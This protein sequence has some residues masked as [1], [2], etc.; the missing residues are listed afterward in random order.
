MIDRYSLIRFF[1]VG[2]KYLSILAVPIIFSIEDV[3]LFSLLLGAERFIS[4]ICSMEVHSYFNRR[5]IHRNHSIEY[6]N[7]QHLPIISIGVMISFIF[8]IFYSIHMSI[9]NLFAYLMIISICGAI[10]NEMIRRAQALGKIDIFSILSA[11]KSICLVI[12]MLFIY[13]YK[14]DNFLFFVQTFAFTSLTICILSIYLFNYLCHFS[15]QK[16]FTKTIN[17]RYLKAAFRTLNKFFIQGSVVFGL[18]LLERMLIANNYGFDMLGP[19]YA[20][21]TL[22]LSSLVLMDIFYW[23][24][25]YSE[26]ILK[27]KDKKLSL[28]DSFRTYGFVISL[29]QLFLLVSFLCVIYFLSFISADW[30]LII[31]NNIIWVIFNLFLIILIPIDTFITYF[32]HSKRL[33]LVNTYSGLLGLFMI[34][35]FYNS[36]VDA[37]FIPLG[38]VFY[39]LL[40]VF[41]K[42]FTNSLLSLRSSN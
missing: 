12:T 5:L 9:V 24:P 33:D 8:G 36:G 1:A 18:A 40:S 41:F 37:F 14:N 30:E 34:I 23:G 13:M 39:Y 35:I 38:I 15:Y 10:L 26:I 11:L 4:F 2:A 20:I 22:A 3:A 25:R 31:T 21:Q 17:R 27:L 32:L 7:N 6:I 28:F 29:F 19:H 16:V 42:I